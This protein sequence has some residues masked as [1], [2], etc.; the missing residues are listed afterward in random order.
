MQQ[1]HQCQQI[2]HPETGPPRAEGHYRIGPDHARPLGWE[3]THLPAVTERHAVLAPGVPV[4][5]QLKLLAF[6]R[7]EWMG[8]REYLFSRCAAGCG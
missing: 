6:Q 1:R 4:A 8:D 2:C 7:M 5:Q 3:R